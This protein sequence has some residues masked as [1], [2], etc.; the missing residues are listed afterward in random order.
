MDGVEVQ[1]QLKGYNSNEVLSVKAKHFLKFIMYFIS[2][3]FGGREEG[4]DRELILIFRVK[5]GIG[6]IWAGP[7]FFCGVGGVFFKCSGSVL[8]LTIR[9]QANLIL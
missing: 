3:L 4:K 6:S 9:V 7:L 8:P 1:I 5:S 2:F